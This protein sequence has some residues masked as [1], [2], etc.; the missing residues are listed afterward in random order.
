MNIKLVTHGRFKEAMPTGHKR[1]QIIYVEKIEDVLGYLSQFPTMVD[2]LRT[3]SYELRV[4]KTIKESR[5]LHIEEMAKLTFPNGA[6]LHLCPVMG[7]NEITTAMLLTALISAA[8][9]IAASIL[10]DLFM[11]IN[12][13]EDK[14]NRKGA[15]YQGGGFTT[16]KQDEP[17]YYN[18]GIDVA[19]GGNLIEGAVTYSNSGSLGSS[20][21]KPIVQAVIRNMNGYQQMQDRLNVDGAK[22]GGGKTISNSIVT[23]ATLLALIALGDGPI[24]GIIGDTYEEKEK[25][26]Y[27]DRQPLRDPGTNQ[28]TYQGTAFDERVGERGQTNINLI[29]GVQN[30]IDGNVEL[31]R[32]SSGG[33]QFYHEVTI[34]NTKADKAVVRLM[35]RALVS[36]DNKKANQESTTVQWGMN[37][38]RQSSGSWVSAGT[39]S[40]TGKSSDPIVLERVITAP[41][42]TADEQDRWQFQI[43]RITP[44]S[45]NDKL[46]N[47]CAYNGHVEIQSVDLTYDGSDTC[48]PVALFALAIDMAQFNQ[49]G[50]YPDVMVRIRGRKVRVPSNYDP[51]T[52]AYTGTWDGS[53]KTAA[54]QNPVW[55]WLHIATDQLQGLGMPDS[56]FSKFELY[57]IA[58]FNDEAVNGRPRYT[59]NKQFREPVDGWP[60][61]VELAS[62]FRAFPYFNGSSVVLVQDRPGQNPNHYVNNTMV[63]DGFFNYQNTELGK[64]YNEVL[65]TYLDPK[66]YYTEKTVRYRDKES[67][68]RNR[69]AGLAAGGV[70]RATFNKV[71]CTNKQ[72]AYDFARMICYVSQHE[73]ETVEFET[74]LGAAAYVPGQLIEIDDITVSNKQFTG[75]ALSAEAG[76]FRLEQPWTQKANASYSVHAVVDNVLVIRPVAMVAQDTTTT[77]VSCNSAGIEWG[78]PFGIVESGGAQPRLFRVQEVADMGEGKFKVTG[79]LHIEGKYEWI[80]Q[81]IPVPEVPWSDLKK[82]SYIPAPTGLKISHSFSQDEALGSRYKLQISW[83][84]ITDPKYA[85]KGYRVEAYNPDNQWIVAYEGLMN[86][87]TISDAKPGRWVV[88]VKPINTFGLSG[89]P[90]VETYDLVYGQGTDLLRPPIFIG[91][92]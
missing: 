58:K 91:F 59:L 82:N 51:I 28:L 62:S 42:P 60:F 68:E 40:Y 76:G 31:P 77:L 11:P 80:E 22:G 33:G 75:R 10:I 67:I 25:H 43:Y 49:G 21:T 90:A 88:S 29:P 18:A 55:H 13:D 56:F 30:N 15:L 54:T 50:N 92:D 87:A 45:T 38:K 81:N 63:A 48:P 61:L 39:F 12:Q 85:L 65:V 79:K 37:V 70:I 14:D 35:I 4:G 16:Q 83:D 71:G 89:D 53:W 23:D 47:A 5:S 46:Q 6:V 57:Q 78:T 20:D 8:A 41:P 19:A 17:L 66:D 2:A 64:Q 27:I 52:R 34:N 24:G 3:G 72:E 73:N 9:S 69:R 32:T 84:A 86:A 44:D 7:G 74:L 26:I 36:T 1:T